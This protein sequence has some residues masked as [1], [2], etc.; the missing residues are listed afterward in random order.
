LIEIRKHTVYFSALALEI[1][2]AAQRLE[3][4]SAEIWEFRHKCV[5]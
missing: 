4:R 5:Y 3:S 2:E 1:I